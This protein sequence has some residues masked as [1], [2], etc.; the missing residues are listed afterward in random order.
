[1][2][3]TA[4]GTAR[5]DTAPVRLRL[6]GV[7]LSELL[8]LVTVRSTWW[9]IVVSAA[10]ALALALALGAVASPEPGVSASTLA[11]G[12]STIQLQFVGLVIAV[13]G[14]LSLGG[15]YS[16]GMIRSTYTA[17]PRRIPSLLARGV[18]VAVA[19]FLV[20]VLTCVGSF[21]VIA[22]LLTAKGA[23]VSLLDDGVIGSLL[24]G[25]F[26]LAVIGA[27]AVGVAALLRS[28]AA[29]IGVSVGVLFV[30]PLLATIAGGL[31]Q[32]PWIAD[33]SPYL[34]S[35]LGLALSSVPSEGSG[36]ESISTT[37]AVLAC[38][39]WLLA[40]WVPA[41]LVTRVRDV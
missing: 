18:V 2:T 22:P 1:M 12:G 24:G 31:L 5:A 35:N 26:S 28:T 30:L 27:F 23:Q 4:P 13:L 37:S 41:L 19:S 39:V 33:V 16:T 25:A 38:G 6:D 10:L 21:A 7:V 8:K 34:L 40:V 9:S 3:A 14:A 36:V 17:V 32:A 20:G 15:E 11:A 29:A